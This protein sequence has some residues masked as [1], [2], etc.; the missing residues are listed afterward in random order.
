MLY[1]YEEAFQNFNMGYASALG[2]VLT[3][4]TALAALILFKTSNRW[5]FYEDSEAAK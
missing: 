4:I 2:W 1:L 3:I 5:V